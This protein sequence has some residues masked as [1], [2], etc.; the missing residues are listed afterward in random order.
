MNRPRQVV[1]PK[2]KCLGKKDELS[3]GGGVEMLLESGRRKVLCEL[4]RTS[5]VTGFPINWLKKKNLTYSSLNGILPQ[6]RLEHLQPI[7]SSEHPCWL[8]RKLP[9]TTR[10]DEVDGK[11]PT[12][13]QKAILPRKEGS[14]P[15]K[16]SA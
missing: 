13:L 12:S 8:L 1:L 9:Q 2:Q 15:P 11:L 14:P 4:P 16:L 7:L 10:K 6:G 3:D 5:Y